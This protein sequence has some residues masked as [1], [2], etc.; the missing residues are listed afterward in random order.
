MTAFISRFVD[1]VYRTEPGVCMED[2]SGSQLPEPY[3]PN[4]PQMTGWANLLR[5]SDVVWTRSSFPS[6]ASA[7]T[8]NGFGGLDGVHQQWEWNFPPTGVHVRKKIA[9]KVVNASGAAVSGATVQCFNT[10]TGLL[11]DTQ[12]T[13]VDGTFVCGDPN[14][15]NNFLVGFLSG[16]PDTFGTTDDNLTGT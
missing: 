16:S 15:T 10:S 9:G 12:T 1:T 7:A 11:V 2:L 13:L 6:Q 5:D 4:A 3:S 14:N 8:S